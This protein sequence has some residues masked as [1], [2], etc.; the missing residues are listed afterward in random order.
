MTGVPIIVT[1]LENLRIGLV[2]CSAFV[3]VGVPTGYAWEDGLFKSAPIGIPG[4]GDCDAGLDICGCVEGE[5][6]PVTASSGDTVGVTK[7]PELQGY[8]RV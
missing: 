4:I 8:G 3:V 5:G 2:W 7:E 1:G 6:L